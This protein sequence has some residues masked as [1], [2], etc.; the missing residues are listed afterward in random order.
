[1]RSSHAEQWHTA[2]YSEY[3]SL[4]DNDTWVLVT[5]PKGRKILTSRWVF[6]VK[7][8]GTGEIDRFKACLVIKGFLQEYGIDYNEIFSPVIRMEVL[9]LLLTI[10]ALLDLEIHQMDVKAAF[11]NGFLEEE[12]SMAQ[13]E[14]FKIPGKE[15][16]VCKLLKILYGLKQAPRVWYHTLS[17]FLKSLGFCKLIKDRCVFCRTR[18]NVTCYIAVYVD[19]LLIIAPTPALVS[20]LNSALKN[21]FS[22]TDLGEVTC[23]LGWSIQR[24]LKGRTIFIHQHKYATKVLDRFSDYIPYTIATPADRNVK[25]SLSSQ[26]GSD[27]E[28]YA[29]KDIPYREA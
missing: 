5:P 22:I 15:H 24:D 28:K 29:M 26:P 18:G 17:V 10:E 7:Y 1:M 25:L 6:V 14:G 9:R 19:D 13:P 3:K 16:L 8:T 21:R 23:L 12:I 11:Q 27:A 2:A 4:M 20:E